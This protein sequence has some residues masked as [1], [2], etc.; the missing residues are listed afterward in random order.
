VKHDTIPVQGREV[1]DLKDDPGV[2]I[3]FHAD[4]G[5]LPW[6]GGLDADCHH[7]VGLIVPPEVEDLWIDLGGEA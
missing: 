3:H 5:D 2:S 7:G 1:E 4:S 6:P